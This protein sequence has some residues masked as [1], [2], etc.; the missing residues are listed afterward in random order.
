MKTLAFAVAACLTFL[1]S[2]APHVPMQEIG[3]F[4]NAA[5]VTFTAYNNLSKIAASEPAETILAKAALDEPLTV[6]FC[7]ESKSCVEVSGTSFQASA[8]NPKGLALVRAFVGYSENL[9][10]V[11]T[12]TLDPELVAS[13]GNLRLAATTF[14]STASGL[15]GSAFPPA[16]AAGPAAGAAFG[17]LA[18]FAVWALG[19]YRETQRYE[20]IKEAVFLVNDP[21]Q[22]SADELAAQMTALQEIHLSLLRAKMRAMSFEYE[23]LFPLETRS[24]SAATVLQEQELRA[25][26]LQKASDLA[27][28]TNAY[29]LLAA[30]D[31]SQVIAKLAAAHGELKKALETGQVTS[32]QFFAALVEFVGEALELSAALEAAVAALEQ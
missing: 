10:K 4:S 2:C 20:A 12:A 5:N 18:D 1:T 28:A 15:A 14:V 9:G 17:G 32:E 26:R 23:S 29:V 11:A 25:L 8:I 22:A 16:L 30:Q 7:E 3:A 21:L 31:P 27:T 24:A 6:S 13:I 19:K